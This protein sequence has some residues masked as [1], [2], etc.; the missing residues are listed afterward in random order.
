MHTADALHDGAGRCSRTAH[1]IAS[2]QF[3]RSTRA[4]TA[5]PR[6]DYPMTTGSNFSATSSTPDP[7]IAAATA[8]IELRTGTADAVGPSCRSADARPGAAGDP[9][10]SRRAPGRYFAAQGGAAH[11]ITSDVASQ[12]RFRNR[13]PID[14]SKL[15]SFTSPRPTLST[16]PRVSPRSL[17]TTL[18]PATPA[19]ARSQGVSGRISGP[20][21]P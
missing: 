2:R 9:W 14:P 8:Q 6:L 20:A 11:A 18:H 7:G 13:R 19:F 15:Y 4:S 10:K 17:P 16:C 3:S 21:H 5:V 1:R 12:H